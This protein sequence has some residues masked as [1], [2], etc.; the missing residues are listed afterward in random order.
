MTFPLMPFAYI[1]WLCR[2]TCILGKL[3]LSFFA[4]G[5]LSKRSRILYGLHLWHAAI[6]T[7]DS[8]VEFRNT[9]D[10]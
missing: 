5:S 6:T 4:F 9:N 2:G 3:Q 1:I 7:Q 10:P 8:P